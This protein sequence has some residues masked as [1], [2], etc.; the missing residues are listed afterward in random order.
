MQAMNNPSDTASTAHNATTFAQKQDGMTRSCDPPPTA[1]PRGSAAERSRQCVATEAEPNE[2][3][4]SDGEGV[5]H[6]SM[7]LFWLGKILAP[8]VHGVA[9]FRIIGPVRSC[10]GTAC[11]SV[12]L[13]MDD[14]SDLILGT[15]MA[16]NAIV[17]G[18]LAKTALI[19]TAGFADT[20][21]IGASG[22]RSRSMPRAGPWP[23]SRT[24]K[25][26]GCLSAQD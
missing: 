6:A 10:I 19:A 7:L 2:P 18:R 26:K 16:I 24:G 23:P 9:D 4:R 13:A 22:P 5:Y 11:H 12:E 21:D 8:R 25:L 3:Q 17:E 1:Q 15:T 20:L 14:I